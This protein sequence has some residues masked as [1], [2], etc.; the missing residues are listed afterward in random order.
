MRIIN[1]S[2]GTFWADWQE[3]KGREANE[4]TGIRHLGKRV[5]QQP[6]SAERTEN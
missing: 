6:V 5:W 4:A 2:A 1:L 3:M